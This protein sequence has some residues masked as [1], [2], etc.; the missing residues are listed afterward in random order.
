M[1]TKSDS[2]VLKAQASR[3]GMRS[4]KDDGCSKVLAGITT[5]DEVLRVTQEV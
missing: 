5:P 1:V 4:L 3:S 2:K